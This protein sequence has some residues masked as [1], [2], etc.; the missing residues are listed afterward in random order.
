M[1]TIKTSDRFKP[2]KEYIFDVIFTEFLG[3][4]FVL[5][6][7]TVADKY[8]VILSNLNSI[9]FQDHFFSNIREENG[10]LHA[11]H[12][13]FN[14]D[15]SNE[16]DS[17]I[18]KLVMIFGNNYYKE[19]R[20]EGRAMVICGF[21]LFASA[22][23]MLTRWEEHVITDKDKYGRFP[24]NKSIAYKHNF[25][26]RPVVNEYVEFLWDILSKLGYSGTRLK[27]KYSLFLTHDVDQFYRYNNFF[28]YIRA[29]VGDI[30]LRHNPGLILRT[31]KD[32]IA[33]KLYNQLD[34]Y[35]T[36]NL[37]MD[38]SDE[39]DIKSHFYFIPAHKG[40]VDAEYDIYDNKVGE[41][42]NK[43]LERG[44]I[45][46]LHGS[47]RSNFNS[48]FFQEEAARL[49]SKAL[50]INEGR[51]HY[52]RFE[53]PYTWQTWNDNG[54]A[55]DSTL[56]IEDDMGFRCGTCYE[57]TVFNIL[58]R[59][60]LKLKEFP[61]IAFEGTLKIKYPDPQEFYN[62]CIKISQEVR[63]YNGTFVF[64]WH[65]NNINHPDWEMYFQ[66]YRD[67]IKHISS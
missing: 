26:S 29:S 65:N 48:D 33:V 46:G 25:Y 67:I 9:T 22:F 24:N 8:E 39:F 35:D 41:V 1:I 36:F 54:F 44:H 28:K 32:Y 18:N 2:E 66:L 43:I 5:K 16:N 34:N 51:Q 13:P 40:E 12:L 23:F 55:C 38:I 59:K 17:G 60:K 61:L 30:I 4:E 27:R 10:Y 7:E 21:D 56:G 47:I 62:H 6:Y 15:C 64:L 11:S 57:Y 50:I 37:L 42:I 63:R 14:I 45:V 19:E 20:I 52:L 53:N 49:R 3:I 31:T 58:T